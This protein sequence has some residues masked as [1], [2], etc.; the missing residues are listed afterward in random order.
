MDVG[1]LIETEIAPTLKAL[2]FLPVSIKSDVWRYVGRYFELLFYYDPRGELTITVNATSGGAQVPL[3]MM[4]GK[5]DADWPFASSIVGGSEECLAAGLRRLA[6]LI[7]RHGTLLTS[8]DDQLLPRL[9]EV[10]LEL[11]KEGW[12]NHDRDRAL[13]AAEQL[14]KAERYVEYI[15]MLDPWERD[16]S[17]AKAAKLEFARRKIA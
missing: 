14:W 6:G 8:Q 10:Q 4:L 16:L 2:G 12:R 9:R 7:Q 11:A 15:A 5:A 17:A 13:A 1:K 3:W